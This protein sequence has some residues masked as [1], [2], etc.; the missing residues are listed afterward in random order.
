MKNQKKKDI[1]IAFVFTAVLAGFLILPSSLGSRGTTPGMSALNHILNNSI[2]TEALTENISDEI[3]FTVISALKLERDFKG[4]DI[5][6]R[7]ISERAE[8]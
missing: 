8:K 2:A 7:Y 3:T 6:M 1:F 5:W 4:V